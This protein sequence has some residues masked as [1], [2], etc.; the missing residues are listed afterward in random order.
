MKSPLCILIHACLDTKHVK[1]GDEVQWKGYSEARH[2][3]FFHLLKLH[4]LCRYTLVLNEVRALLID[5]FLINF[6]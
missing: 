4:T 3:G 2:L 6:A 1:R 5:H